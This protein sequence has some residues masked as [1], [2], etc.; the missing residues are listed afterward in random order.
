MLGRLQQIVAL[1][2]LPRS[3]TAVQILTAATKHIERTSFAQE[4]LDSN[5][6]L[7]PLTG[8]HVPAAGL[9]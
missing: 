3:A 8:V 6:W 1:L 9:A 5:A 4:L 2:G 7:A